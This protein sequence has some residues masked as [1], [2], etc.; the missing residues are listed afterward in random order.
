MMSIAALAGIVMF[1]YAAYAI[2]FDRTPW[3][4]S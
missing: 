2:I 4:R 3:S 1:M